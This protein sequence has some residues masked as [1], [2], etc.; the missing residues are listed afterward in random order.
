MIP[1]ALFS[2]LLASL[3]GSCLLTAK[4]GRASEPIPANVAVMS[5]RYE[6]YKR[7]Y[8]AMKSIQGE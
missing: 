7:L 8:P 2:A 1:K 4:L 6:S 5:E 3:I